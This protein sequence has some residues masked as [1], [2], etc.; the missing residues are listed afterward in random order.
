VA[1]EYARRFPEATRAMV[2]EGVAG[3]EY[4]NPLPHARAGQA[5]LDSLLVACERDTRCAGAYP[6]LRRDLALL[7]AR[8]DSAPV[9]VTI[10]GRTAA[11]PLLERDML[12]YGLH[13]L[14]FSNP[15][16]AAVPFLVTRAAAGDYWPIA[17][18]LAQV[19]SGLAGQIDL[20]MQLSVTCMEDAPRYTLEDV[21]REAPG[22]YLREAFTRSSK[23]Q[24]DRWPVKPA[25]PLPVVP[26]GTD[27]LLISGAHDPATPL[28]YASGV[29]ARMPRAIALVVPYGAHVTVDA[30]VNG[31]IA[32]Y[33]ERLAVSD[34][35]RGCLAT[36]RR[37]PF[38]VPGG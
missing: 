12:A 35:E 9:P 34:A 20:G 17:N 26:L 7:W 21:A 30:C 23:E 8:L 29:A 3:P 18:V 10:P 2:L 22:T 31:I 24:C 36:G 19:A 25:T 6:T 32:R 14:L 5:A 38:L 11:P 27:A 16:A 33:V 4:P 15:S 37:P 28:S 1:M 13:L